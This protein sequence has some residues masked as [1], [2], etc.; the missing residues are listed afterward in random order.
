MS[1]TDQYN[2]KGQKEDML[3]AN[4]FKNLQIPKILPVM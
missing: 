4:K 2:N 3:S 1:A